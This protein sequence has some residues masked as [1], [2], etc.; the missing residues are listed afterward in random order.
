MQQAMAQRTSARLQAHAL[1]AFSRWRLMSRL[2]AAA[3]VVKIWHQQPLALAAAAAL[4][5]DVGRMWLACCWLAWKRCALGRWGEGRGLGRRLLGRQM[6]LGSVV[7]RLVA[8]LSA[9][10]AQ[11]PAPRS[12]CS[13]CC[14]P[15][16]VGCAAEA[17]N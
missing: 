2:L 7:W 5:G 13:G 3:A 4:Q 12:T 14:R 16:S 10:R 11:E 1:A 17:A 15:R 8:W 9:M 6:G